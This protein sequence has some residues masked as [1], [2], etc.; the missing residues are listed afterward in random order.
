MVVFPD[1]RLHHSYRC[2]FWFSQ[3]HAHPRFLSATTFR[4]VYL[5]TCQKSQAF[6]EAEVGLVMLQE[7]CPAPMIICGLVHVRH[8]TKRPQ[9]AT[10]WPHLWPRPLQI[11]QEPLFC[12]GKYL[13]NIKLFSW[14]YL[15]TFWEMVLILKCV[16]IHTLWG[17]RKNEFSESRK[18]VNERI[19]NQIKSLE[20][21]CWNN[22]KR[23]L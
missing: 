7:A 3:M 13:Y 8:P 18:V 6:E 20:L 4:H 2:E 17:T 23:T 11:I 5:D 15:Q 22:M 10:G 16:Y 14:I 12:R 21:K 9:T 1:S 19:G